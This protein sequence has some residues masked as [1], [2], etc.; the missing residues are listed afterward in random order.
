MQQQN[1]V[2]V[3]L[4]DRLRELHERLS[5]EIIRE[6]EL[7]IP[8]T[9]PNGQRLRGIA[10]PGG[11]FLARDRKFYG[12]LGQPPATRFTVLSYGDVLARVSL[13]Q[14]VEA[15][16]RVVTDRLARRRKRG[17]ALHNFVNFL[18]R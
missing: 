3:P 11:V 1:D 15:L 13:E 2:L 12:T 7:P 5:Y 4:H 16:R 9:L 14:I 17:Q 10:F 18:T 6:L 8:A